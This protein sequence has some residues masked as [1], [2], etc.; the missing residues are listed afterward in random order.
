MESL[1]QEA[2]F[3]NELEIKLAAA[4]ASVR[5]ERKALEQAEAHLT[6]AQAAQDILQHLAQAVQQ[7]AH[8]KLAEVVSLCLST[9]FEDPY[10]FKIIF[11]RKRGRTEASLRF[12]R[13]GLEVDPL[14]ASGGGVVDVA[15]FALR[16]ACLVLHRPRLRRL[17]VLDEAFRFVSREYQ[18]NVRQMLEQLAE[19]MGLQIVQVTHI[20]TL[21]AGT[22]IEL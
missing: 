5:V 7:R 22:V 21:A 2:S 18:A 9:V 3:I 8:T 4:K 6:H 20:P 16:V 11:E 14:T 19:K 13:N 10:E 17:V 15:A 1:E 12:V